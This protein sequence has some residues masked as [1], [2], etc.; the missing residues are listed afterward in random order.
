MIENYIQ[1]APNK[2]SNRNYISLLVFLFS[3][4]VLAFVISVFTVHAVWKHL[5]DGFL[6]LTNVFSFFFLLKNSSFRR[7]VYYVIAVLLLSIT[8]IGILFKI[9]HWPGVAI[10]LTVGL[11]GLSILY[12]LRFFLKQNKTRQDFLRAL[13]IASSALLY[14][15]A[16]MHILTPRLLII[17]SV[18]LLLTVA[19]MCYTCYKN[20]E[21]LDK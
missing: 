19:D 11:C 13:L 17:P 1:M 7:T 21:L 20:P 10:L 4:S 15:S 18:V 6:F 3:F 14:W 16:L 5:A 2:M 8:C 12:T 9:M